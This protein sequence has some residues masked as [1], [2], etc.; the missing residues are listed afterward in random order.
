MN[1]SF[2]S[3]QHASEIDHLPLS[4]YIACKERERRIEQTHLLVH[5]QLAENLSGV[6]KML[7]LI[8]SMRDD[9]LALAFS[10]L[11]ISLLSLCLFRG[12]GEGKTLELYTY[13]FALNT[14]NGR[15]RIIA[16][17]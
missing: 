16:S 6:Q 3:C 17:Q 11:P 7:I 2:D 13:F 15:L 9:S 8:Y 14:S 12:G 4:Y 1:D 5:I 10:F